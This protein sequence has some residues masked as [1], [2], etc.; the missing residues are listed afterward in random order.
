MTNEQSLSLPTPGAV[1]ADDVWRFYRNIYVERRIAGFTPDE[2]TKL[3]RYDCGFGNMES[4]HAYYKQAFTK[5]FHRA[6]QAIFKR[7]TR[8]RVLD[9]C[10]G[11]GMQSIFFAL[12]GAKV[13]GMDFDQAQ[14]DTLR[15]R[16]AVYSGAAGKPLGIE[17]FQ[18]D[19]KTFDFDSLGDFDVVYS[20]GGAGQF[21]TAKDLFA[22][23]GAVVKPGGLLILK[24]GNPECW[25]LKAAGIAPLDS[26]YGDYMREAVAHGFTVERAAGTTALPRPLWIAELPLHW[27]DP[28]LGWVNGLQVHF[29]YIFRKNP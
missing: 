28:L 1:S 4:R 15:K 26:S 22:R 21:M 10:C 16:E 13:V 19:V 24:N 5:P 14:L 27:L 25:W 29:E 7:F 20:H 9:V 11:T 12:M 6:V 23:M 17:T 18:G 3:F 8:P 2:D